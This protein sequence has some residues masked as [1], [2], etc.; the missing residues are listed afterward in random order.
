MK[1]I[2]AYVVLKSRHKFHI[3]AMV[4]FKIFKRKKYNTY[5]YIN[6]KL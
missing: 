1:K 2:Y 5:K 3:S 4:D 6:I